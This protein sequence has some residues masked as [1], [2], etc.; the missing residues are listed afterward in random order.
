MLNAFTNDHIVDACFIAFPDEKANGTPVLAVDDGA[1][2][3]AAELIGVPFEDFR[4]AVRGVIDDGNENTLNTFLFLPDE[5]LLA[6]SSAYLDE[7]DHSVGSLYFLINTDDIVEGVALFVI[8]YILLMLIMLAIEAWLLTR[9]MQRTI[10]GPLESIATAAQGYSK[11]KETGTI[12]TRHFADLSIHTGNEIER[13]ASALT[14][15]EDDLE[16]YVD[17]IA[18]IS[19]EQERKNTELRMAAQIQKSA[20]PSVFPAFPTGGNS[21]STPRWIPRAR[22]AVTSMTSS[23]WTMTTCAW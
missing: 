5:G 6:V 14:S 19:A 11:D 8:R 23:L 18:R 16:T 3:N 10:V 20:L 15:M 13:L 4:D 2:D 1:Q 7:D 12:G 17:D 9:R 21:T 22:L